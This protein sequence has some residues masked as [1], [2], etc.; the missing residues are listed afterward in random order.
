MVFFSTST[1]NKPVLDVFDSRNTKKCIKHMALG[2][3][4]GYPLP[5]YDY[6]SKVMFMV[7]RS[8]PRV[9]LY[10][11][12]HVQTSGPQL[13]SQYSLKSGAHG[14]ALAPKTRC[15]LNQHEV[16][17]LYTLTPTAIEVY[18]VKVPRRTA[19]FD[20]K[21][22]PDTL[23]TSQATLTGEEWL[24]GA[25][26][27][28]NLLDIKSLV[29]KM[30]ALCGEEKSSTTTTTTTTSSPTTTKKYSEKELLEML[31]SVTDDDGKWILDQW[32]K[33]GPKAMRA[34]L[35]PTEELN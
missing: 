6:D 23:D 13:Q 35:S 28:P 7:L 30:D 14:I 25:N 19:R 17:R 33:V 8:S 32:E 9:S 3:N 5:V 34:S 18:G 15:T 20:P 11:F 31:K 27:T 29:S 24:E 22:W 4:N 26:K 10:D 2:N 12:T 16:A 21:L 1:Q